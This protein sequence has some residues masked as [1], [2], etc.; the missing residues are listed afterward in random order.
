MTTAKHTPGPWGINPFTADYEVSGTDAPFPELR[1]SALRQLGK[2][3]FKAVSVG[4]KSGQVA[5]I[6]L[7]ESNEHNAK[8]I[9]AAPDMLEA[10]E[11]ARMTFADL[12]ASKRKGYFVEAPRIIAAAI[13]K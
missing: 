8:L 7:D 5:I 12:E 10:L 2:H 13:T 3:K 11:Y 6:P 4:T 1:Q 9:A